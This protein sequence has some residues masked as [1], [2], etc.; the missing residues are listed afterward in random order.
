MN[1]AFEKIESEAPVLAAAFHKF[2]VSLLAE[3]LKYREK[4]LHSR[5]IMTR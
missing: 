1:L 2:I 5:L 4:E 3:R